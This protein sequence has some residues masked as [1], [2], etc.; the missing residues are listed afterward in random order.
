MPGHRHPDRTTRVPGGPA[1]RPRPSRGPHPHRQTGRDR[2]VPVPRVHDQRRL[3]AAGVDRRRPDRLDPDHPARRKPW[4]RP[5]RN[6]CATDCSTPPPGASAAAA[7]PSSRSPQAGPGPTSSSSRSAASPASDNPCWP[8]QPARPCLPTIKDPRRTG[9]QAGA[10]ALPANRR[11]TTRSRVAPDHD[12][13]RLSERGRLGLYNSGIDTQRLCPGGPES[14]TRMEDEMSS[15]L[16]RLDLSPSGR[17][18]P[19]TRRCQVSHH[20]RIIYLNLALFADGAKAK[21]AYLGG[22][23]RPRGRADSTQAP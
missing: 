16:V 10:P 13:S 8:D 23:D 11:S 17:G 4:P 1:P 15:V 5:S 19:I 22:C 7:A 3:V 12:H 14:G 6:C 9:H 18:L 20:P 21:Q 2:P